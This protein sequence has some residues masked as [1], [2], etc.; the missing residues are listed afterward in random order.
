MLHFKYV[1]WPR[2]PFQ[3]KQSELKSVQASCPGWVVRTYSNGVWGESREAPVQHRAQGRDVT[4][5]CESQKCGW[6]HW[7]VWGYTEGTLSRPSEQLNGQMSKTFQQRVTWSS[8]WVWHAESWPEVK[9]CVIL[10]TFR[11]E[12]SSREPCPHAFTLPPQNLPQW[13]SKIGQR[14]KCLLP[15]LMAWA[16]SSVPETCMVEAENQRQ[17]AG[18]WPS[19]TCWGTLKSTHTQKKKIGKKIF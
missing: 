7:T 9:G 2:E 13:S 5:L 6:I 16:L 12:S 8:S 18:L 17:Q 19:D 3:A 11:T 14:Q 1:P 15:S 10:R 4:W